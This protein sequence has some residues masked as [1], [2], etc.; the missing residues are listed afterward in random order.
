MNIIISE[1]RL[2]RL[3]TKYID[4]MLGVLEGEK[5]LL[6]TRVAYFDYKNRLVFVVDLKIKDKY[7]NH[8][9]SVSLQ[10]LQRL[11]TVFSGTDEDKIN[12]IV[13]KYFSEIS[14]MTLSNR[15]TYLGGHD[16]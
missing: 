12:E 10:F 1:E 6:N 9:W 15:F 13:I 14:G 8:K 4:H 16:F 7:E 3:V 2:N 11:Y 5:N